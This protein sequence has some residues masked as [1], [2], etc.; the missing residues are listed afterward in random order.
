M[1]FFNGI[2][3][4]LFYVD[5]SLV[6]KVKWVSQSIRSFF[7]DFSRETSK[8]Y[9]ELGDNNKSSNYEEINIY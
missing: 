5:S 7:T 2:S 4:V 1:I 8:Q 9:T 3:F 6:D